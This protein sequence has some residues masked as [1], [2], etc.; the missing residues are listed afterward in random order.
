[1]SALEEIQEVEQRLLMA[2]LNGNI[3]ELDTLI[4]DE[5][6]VVGPDGRLVGKADDLAAHRSG[7]LRIRSMLPL[8]TTIKLLPDVAIVFV[9]MAIEVT[10]QD[11]SFAGRY[12]YTR[13]WSRQKATWK[14][15]AGHISSVDG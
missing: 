15:T 11:Q 14:I 3:D 10:V 5:L 2:M 12:R 9:L 8:E 1:M 6:L 4:S 7:T 13:I